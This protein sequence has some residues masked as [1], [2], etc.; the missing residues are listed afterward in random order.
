M[1]F[2]Q[3][4]LKY[5]KSSFCSDAGTCVEVATFDGGVV[6][7]DSK[8]PDSSALHFSATEWDA[9]IRGVKKGEFNLN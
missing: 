8:N 6:V 5:H 1:K 4:V 2:N 9:F 3:Y 7:R